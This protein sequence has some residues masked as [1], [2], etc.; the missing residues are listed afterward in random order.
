MIKHIRARSIEVIRRE[1]LM[2]FN[3]GRFGNTTH[4]TPP[5]LYLGR[6][7]HVLSFAPCL[8][9]ALSQGILM[10]FVFDD[11]L[12]FGCALRAPRPPPRGVIKN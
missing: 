9:V 6:S 4:T 2:K 10:T 12:V 11:I 8:G 7:P 3:V 1:H 5:P